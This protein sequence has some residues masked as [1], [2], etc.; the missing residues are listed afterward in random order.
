[1]ETAEW[2]DALLALVAAQGPARARFILDH[3]AELARSPTLAWSPEL[4]TP[5]VNTIAVDEQPVSRRPRDR[6]KARIPDAL[7]RIGDG[8]AREHGVR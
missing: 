2:R 8:G 1:M 7:E 4:V 5:Y 6:G 3:L